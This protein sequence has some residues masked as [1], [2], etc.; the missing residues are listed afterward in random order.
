MCGRYTS[1][2]PAAELARYFEADDV[3]APD[4]GPRYNV[5]PTEE[6]YAVAHAEHGRRLG[7]M[8]WGL[9][10]WWA[11][12]LSVGSRMINARA[13]SLLERRAY[14]GPFERRRCLV[15]AD[16]FY[17]WEPREDGSKQAWFVRR[18]DDEPLAFAGLWSSWRPPSS[19]EGDGRVVSCAIVTTAAN[20]TV[21]PVHDR[22]PVVLPPSAWGTWLDPANTAVTALAEL[23]V[24][25]P[26]ALLERVPVGPLVNDVRND[27]RA[28]VE[29]VDGR[30]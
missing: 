26:D 9:V 4:L 12:G 23:L 10:P 19:G 3:V 29:P 11:D 24:P 6:V 2:T 20:A 28:L 1:T 7:T 21:G 15:P 16:G 5:A 14:R 8:R 30:P 13:E 17:E 18:R 22:M 25:A 27:G